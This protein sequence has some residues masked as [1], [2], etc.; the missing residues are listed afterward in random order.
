MEEIKKM[1]APVIARASLIFPSK[2]EAEMFTGAKND[3]EGCKLWASQGKLVVLKNGE[4]GCRIFTGDQVLD[5][6]GFA[7]TEVDP[8]GAGDTFCG[9]FLVTLTEGKDL[10]HCGVFANAAGALSVQ[11]QG[12]MEGAPSRAELETFIKHASLGSER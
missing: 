2:T 7:I 6:P 1:C 10:T 3:E 4:A 5:I 8:T 12:P 11:K 9:A